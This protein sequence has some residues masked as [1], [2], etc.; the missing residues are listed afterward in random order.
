LTTD[1][2]E[3]SIDPNETSTDSNR[4][5][6]DSN[7]TTTVLNGH[8]TILIR[9]WKTRKNAGKLKVELG[10]ASETEAGSVSPSPAEQMLYK[11]CL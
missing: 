8:R 9:T 1:P 7:G 11:C 4:I 6:T 5:A 2:N 10:D 3:T